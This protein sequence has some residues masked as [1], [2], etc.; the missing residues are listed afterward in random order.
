MAMMRPDENFVGVEVHKPGV[1]AA[2]SRLEAEGLSNVKI[3]QG[4][5]I[6][7]LADSIEDGALSSCCIFFPD[8]FP[9]DRDSGRR[10]VRPL[11]LSLLS[12]KLRPGGLLHV[13][14][15][16]QVYAEHTARVVAQQNSRSSKAPDFTERKETQG[17][18]SWSCASRRSPTAVVA[19]AISATAG[20]GERIDSLEEPRYRWVEQKTPGAKPVGDA[21]GPQ[22]KQAGGEWQSSG[23]SPSEEVCV[24]WK[25]G[26]TA[27]RPSSRPVTKYEERA[28]E[29]GTRVRDFRY[30]LELPSQRH[31]DPPPLTVSKSRE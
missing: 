13:A 5:A 19:A 15:D 26:E 23:R 29:A 14:T 7:V 17:T 2:L 8:P 6:T 28:R 27:H 24:R 10:L 20:N 12:S 4:D 16:V 30:R 25:G 22:R 18:R 1:A 9:Q 11:L 31:P 3:V 21:P